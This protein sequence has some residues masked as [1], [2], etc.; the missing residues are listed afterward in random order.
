M[1]VKSACRPTLLGVVGE[2]LADA[3]RHVVDHFLGALFVD[4]PDEHALQ[5]ALGVRA[6]AGVIAHVAAARGVKERVRRFAKEAAVLQ[7][8]VLVDGR[9][10]IACAKADALMGESLRQVIQPDG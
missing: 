2:H 4:V 9:A 8:V 1:R 7:H 3:F 6:H 10:G 5:N